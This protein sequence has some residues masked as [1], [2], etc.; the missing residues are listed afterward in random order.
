MILAKA[1]WKSIH[2]EGN[3][4]YFEKNKHFVLLAEVCIYQQQV[5]KY[6]EQQQ[7]IQNTAT[8]MSHM[9]DGN[10]SRHPMLTPA[11][12]LLCWGLNPFDLAKWFPFQ[13]LVC[14]F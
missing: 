13:P 5:F 2:H 14:P 1:L 9:I 3:G 10:Q 11:N 4:L 7:N 6:M 12:E 8:R